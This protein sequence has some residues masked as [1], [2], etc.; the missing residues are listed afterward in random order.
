MFC[1]DKGNNF[2]EHVMI[3]SNCRF[4]YAA[5]EIINCPKCKVIENQKLKEENEQLKAEINIHVK[6]VSRA[7]YKIK[8]LT[9]ENERLKTENA[10]LCAKVPSWAEYHQ[11]EFAKH[12]N[13]LF[14]NTYIKT[15]EEK[16]EAKDKE[17]EALKQEIK[18][19]QSLKYHKDGCK[20]LGCCMDISLYNNAFEYIKEQNTQRTEQK[21]NC[22]RCK[23][24]K[25][26][27]I[28]KKLYIAINNSSAPEGFEF[29]DCPDCTKPKCE[30]C[31]DEKKIVDELKTFAQRFLFVD[32]G[33]LYS[34]CPDCCKENN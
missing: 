2:F 32:M 4:K 17:L 30:T 6:A 15:L 33:V 8:N 24:Y 7:V 11:K 26:I 9:H 21:Y 23:D 16:L 34:K 22:E 12:T 14:I 31:G 1:F 13:D 29:D 3:C 10:D 28:F 25:K 20:C 19:I 5:N 27:L 18:N